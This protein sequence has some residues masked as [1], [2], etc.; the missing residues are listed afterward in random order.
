MSAVRER[1]QYFQCLFP[2]HGPLVG[3]MIG[4]VSR[5]FFA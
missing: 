5:A 2:V 3:M 1:V 4:F